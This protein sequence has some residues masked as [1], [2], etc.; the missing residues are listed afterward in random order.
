MESSRAEEIIT[1]YN[2]VSTGLIGKTLV[3][4]ASPYK[5]TDNKKSK[6]YPSEDEFEFFVFLFFTLYLVIES[7][8]LGELIEIRDAIPDDV[9]DTAHFV[10]VRYC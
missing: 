8:G 4:I 3:P 7:V 2:I 9:V 10:F 5:T 6:S 1:V